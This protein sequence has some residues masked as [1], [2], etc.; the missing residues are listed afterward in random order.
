MLGSVRGHHAQSLADV[1]RFLGKRAAS[2]GIRPRTQPEHLVRD[3]VGHDKRALGLHTASI[4]RARGGTRAEGPQDRRP[5]GDSSP[6]TT[7]ADRSW[8]ATVLTAV[9]KTK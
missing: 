1:R 5:A 3:R 9:S 7:A 6:T 2:G 8:L 4:A